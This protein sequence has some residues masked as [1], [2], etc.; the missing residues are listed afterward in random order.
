LDSG[1]NFN[2]V[3]CVWVEVWL[4]LTAL[5][6]PTANSSRELMQRFDWGSGIMHN[7]AAQRTHAKRHTL[8]RPAAARRWLPR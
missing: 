3:F 1:S 8:Q 7:L 4:L 2:R 5:S 6:K